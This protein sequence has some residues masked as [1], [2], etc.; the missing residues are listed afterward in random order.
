MGL[1]KFVDRFH[2]SS[3]VEVVSRNSRPSRADGAAKDGKEVDGRFKG[4]MV[5]LP[6]KVN[7]QHK[8]GV[9]I[10]KIIPLS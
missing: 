6:D 9:K 3:P 2:A 8:H 4:I 5:A 7:T 10:L 1:L